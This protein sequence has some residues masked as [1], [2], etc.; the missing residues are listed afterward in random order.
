LGA[1]KGKRQQAR[2]AAIGTTVLKRLNHVLPNVIV[3]TVGQE[4]H[5]K[6]LMSQFHQHAYPYNLMLLLITAFF[7]LSVSKLALRLGG[8]MPGYVPRY[9]S[10]AFKPV[11]KFEVLQSFL[12]DDDGV[13]KANQ[14]YE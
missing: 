1:S 9:S 11:N 14:D 4:M 12:T 13:F 5:C 7:S 3:Q 10:Q 8:R 6:K 2:R